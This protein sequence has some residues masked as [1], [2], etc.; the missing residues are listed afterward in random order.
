MTSVVKRALHKIELPENEQGNR[1]SNEDIQPV[2]PERQ[3]WGPIQFVELWFLI[4][5]NVSSYQTG[6]SLLASGMTYWQAIIVILVGNAL[7]SGFAVLNSVSGAQSHLGFPIVCRSVWGMW[8]AYFPI[9][10]RILTSIVWYGVQAVIGGKMIY[11]CLRSIWMDLDERIPNTL[12]EGIGITTAQFMGYVLFNFLCCIF[13]WF[14]PQQLRPYFHGASVVVGIT[15]IC[16]LGWAVGTSDGYGSVFNAKTTIPSSELGWQ[17]SAGIMSVIG[18]IASGILNQ[19]DF[20]RFAKRP[21]HVTWTQGISFFTSSSMNAIVGVVVTAATQEQYG[22]GTALWD[23][24]TLFMAIQDQ[25]GSGGRAATFF[26]GIVFIVS[27][28]S[29][30]VV[31]NVLAGGLDVASVFPKYINLRRGAYVLA[32]LSVTPNPWQQLSSGSTFLS[33]LSAYAVF[34]GPMIGL[35]C[36]H[37]YIIQKRRFHVPDLYIGSKKS[38]Y[39]YYYGTNWRTVVAWVCAVIPSMPGFV[40]SVNPSLHVGIGASRI[41]SL[42]FVLG[43]VLSAIIAW[44]LHQIFPFQYPEISAIVA[45]MD[46]ASSHGEP[47][48]AVIEETKMAS[49]GVRNV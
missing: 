40:H 17:M 2:P 34:L 49:K 1:W 45:E 35:L 39:W 42:S 37:F 9:L 29:I 10:N 31:G 6:S 12:P 19:N 4:N 13:I 3:T 43:F 27:Q 44:L 33:V 16:L 41:F 46:S 38:L 14:R 5:L 28:L 7:A 15:L 22:H 18:S 36:V 26:L 48:E 30:N 32:A 24:S 47:V 21:S 8:G 23:P 25:D 11:I 20:T